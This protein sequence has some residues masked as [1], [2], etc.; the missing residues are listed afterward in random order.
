MDA[1]R[2]T[3][4]WELCQQT[5]TT[6]LQFTPTL[7]TRGGTTGTERDCNININTNPSNIIEMTRKKERKK[8]RHWS[9]KIHPMRC[10]CNCSTTRSLWFHFIILDGR[11]L[12]V[13]LTPEPTKGLASQCR[14]SYGFSQRIN[15]H[16]EGRPFKRLPYLFG[17]DFDL[18][19]LL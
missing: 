15:R 6:T 4:R 13:I 1:R 8:E 11:N 9:W 17:P 3:L 7:K 2:A 12:D 14:L 18:H 5:L 19:I 16:H 10:V